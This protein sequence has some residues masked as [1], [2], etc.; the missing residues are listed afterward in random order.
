MTT[1]T[2][3]PMNIMVAT[4]F[5][6]SGALDDTEVIINTDNV[7]SYPNLP[8]KYPL[9]IEMAVA[10]QHNSKMVI[11]GGLP[12]TSDCYSYSNNQWNIEA[13][14]LEPARYGAMSVEIR[15]GEWL[16]MGGY[17]Y[18][19]SSHVLSDTQLLKNGIFIQGPDLPEPILG[20][21]SVML[22]QT[23][24]FVA[25]GQSAS[26]FSMSPRNYLM[27][28][29]SEQW[30]QI[31]DRTLTPYRLHSSGTFFNSTAGEIQIANIGREGIE[32]Y[33]PGDDSW[34]EI[35]F[36]FPLTSLCYSTAIQKGTDSFILIGGE[37]NLEDYS[38]DVY[39]FDGNG[40]SV[41]NKNVLQFPRY[42]HVAMQIS[43][44]DFTCNN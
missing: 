44:E 23:H 39:L 34:H 1:T 30:T 26:N 5:G 9:E 4:G 29:N 24:L 33:S 41:Y 32:V 3:T 42:L 10:M 22:N 20:G 35:N 43:C 2:S 13:F 7:T 28:I 12:Y 36:P 6:S 17:Y 37:T 11:C 40:F 27:D 18:D 25:A 15:P 21:S 8:A 19:G 14:R 38:G 31:A 16:V